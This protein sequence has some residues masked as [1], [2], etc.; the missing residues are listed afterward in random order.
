MLL[1]N[2]LLKA[3]GTMLLLQW[4]TEGILYLAHFLCLDLVATVSS[5]WRQF[6]M[7]VC[8]FIWL[9]CP[10]LCFMFYYFFVLIIFDTSIRFGFITF[11]RILFLTCIVIIFFLA[12][13]HYSV[14]RL[15]SPYFPAFSCGLVGHAMMDC[16]VPQPHLQGISGCHLS[17]AHDWWARALFCIKL[18]MM[19][20]SYFFLNFWQNMSQ[21]CQNLSF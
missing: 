14:A 21:C 4:L 7:E 13:L 12:I 2:Q 18:N 6:V 11:Q 10:F 1:G 17:S 20:C 3:H 9:L 19:S 16:P 8:A 15:S 5:N